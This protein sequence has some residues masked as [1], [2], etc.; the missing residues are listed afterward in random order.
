MTLYGVITAA[1]LMKLSAIIAE[2]RK[3]VAEATAI[4][5]KIITIAKRDAEGIIARAKAEEQNVILQAKNETTLLKNELF[6][7]IAKV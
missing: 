7:K 5:K 6:N 2:Y 4:E 1:I 3:L